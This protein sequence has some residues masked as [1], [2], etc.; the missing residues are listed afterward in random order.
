MRTP[1]VCCSTAHMSVALGTSWS[2]LVSNVVETPVCLT[3]TTGDSPVTVMVSA[4]VASWRSESM[5]KV[6]P[7]VT[8][9]PSRFTVWNPASSNFNVVRAGRES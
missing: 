8:T 6:T 3:S 7:L 5:V 1:G 4:T 9:T 2:S